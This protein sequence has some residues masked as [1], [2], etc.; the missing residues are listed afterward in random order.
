MAVSINHDMDQGA[1]FSFS[2]LAKDTNGN[3]VNLSSGCTA[4]AQMR[5]H[6]SSTSY[7]TL[8][9]SL[10]GGTGYISVSLGSTGTA[11]IKAGTYF[12]DVELVSNN[13]NT[14]Q[15]L[16]QGMITV[17]PEVTRI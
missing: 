1:N 11:A 8:T 4:Y 15:R 7:T 12:Y 17:Y 14:T 3:A 6:Y 9:A 2:I 10:T 13:G 16:V 5:K